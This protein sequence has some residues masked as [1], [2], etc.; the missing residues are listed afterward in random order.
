MT[1][2]L[3]GSPKASGSNSEIFLKRLEEKLGGACSR[4]SALKISEDT[5]AALCSADAVVL[6]FPLYVDALPSH[7][8]RFLMALEEYAK[9]RGP[10]QLPRFYAVS[11]CGFYEGS[12]NRSALDLLAH[13]CRRSGFRWCGGVGLGCAGAAGGGMPQKFQQPLN[14]LI[15]QLAEAVKRK[16]PLCENRY[17]SMAFPR[18]MYSLFGNLGWNSGARENG[19][20]KKDLYRRL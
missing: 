14:D 13:F 3:N 16:A 5:F 19:L 4:R 1:V 9:A 2:L 17:A 7:L 11:Q 10:S 15:G 18:W 20:R 12:Q 8:L 6:A